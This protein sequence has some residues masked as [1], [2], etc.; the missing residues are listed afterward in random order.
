M[1][2]E[3][4][5]GV[6]GVGGCWGRVCVGGGWVGRTLKCLLHGG[7]TDRGN[8]SFNDE[9]GRPHCRTGLLDWF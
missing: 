8:C 9:W 2:D 3:V 1:G 7:S 5:V 4:G 6:G